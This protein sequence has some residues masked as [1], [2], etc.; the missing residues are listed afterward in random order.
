MGKK[1]INHLPIKLDHDT[2]KENLDLGLT[3]GYGWR[4]LDKHIIGI[5]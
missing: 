3:S 5:F 1:L 4:P 2:F